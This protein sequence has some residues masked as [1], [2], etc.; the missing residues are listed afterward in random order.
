MA[1]GGSDGRTDHRVG[2]IGDA[3]AW[4]DAGCPDPA[5]RDR[6]NLGAQD[7][8]TALIA[9]ARAIS[10]TM[11][12][13]PY[14]RPTRRTDRPAGAD[15][16]ACLLLK[17]AFPAA[18]RSAALGMPAATH[19]VLRWGRDPLVEGPTSALFRNHIWLAGA[20]CPRRW[21]SDVSASRDPE[22]RAMDRVPRLTVPDCRS[23]TLCRRLRCRR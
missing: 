5:D 23:R 1:E 22:R 10:E 20:A 14:D 11:S 7:E 21:R 12:R 16:A 8:E 4:Q 17:L 18:R 6:P 3:T 2:E 13:D 15:S 9:K 19:A